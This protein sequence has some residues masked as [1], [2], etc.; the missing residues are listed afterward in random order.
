M[1]ACRAITEVRREE[2]VVIAVGEPLAGIATACVMPLFGTG[3][4]GVVAEVM[5][6]P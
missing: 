2:G 4:L 5:C 1:A 3:N 6:M